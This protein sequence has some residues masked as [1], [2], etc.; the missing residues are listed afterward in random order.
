MQMFLLTGASK[1]L[2]ID[3]AT[4]LFENVILLPPLLLG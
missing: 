2:K 4:I 3:V 1:A